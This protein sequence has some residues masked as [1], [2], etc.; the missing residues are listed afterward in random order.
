MMDRQ[1]PRQRGGQMD[2]QTD[3]KMYKVITIGLHRL[4]GADLIIFKRKAEL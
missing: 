2:G 3:R 4:S 1:T